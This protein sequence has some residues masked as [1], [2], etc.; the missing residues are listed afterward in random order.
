MALSMKSAASAALST[1][2]TRSVAARR[3]VA[4]VADMSAAKRVAQ[5]ATVGV[6]SLALTLGANAAVIKLGSD[7]GALVFEPSN[8]TV[9]S[10]E[11]ITFT[12]NVGFPHN[13]VFDE[14]AVPEGVNADAISRD[15]YLNA[16]GET[17]ELKLTTP[18]VYGYYCEPHQG[19]GMVGSIT[20]N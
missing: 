8:V 18:G 17:Y 13:V 16:P 2:T 12:N 7:S 14:D 11:T 4:V 6:A 15:D 5:A 10:G 19:A 1:K 3:S 9:S 20:V